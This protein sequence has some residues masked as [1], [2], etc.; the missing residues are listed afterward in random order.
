VEAAA[1]EDVSGV[2]GALLF[3][4]GELRF[5]NSQVW[6][7]FVELAGGK[8][9]PVVVM[10]TAARDPRASGQAV[11]DNLRKYGANAEVVLIA[12]KLRDIDFKAAVQDQA[13]VDKL[14][15]ARGIWFI[16][17]DQ[18][19]IT[20]ALLTEDGK[21]TPALEAI[22]EA[23]RNGAVIGGSSAG[24][25]VMSRWMFAN[26]P[27]SSLG[28]LLG[29]M[30]SGHGEAIDQGLGFIGD[31]W[32]V[33]QHFLTRGRF[34]RAL[35]AMHLLKL[36]YGIGV[37]EDTAVVF[38]AGKFEVVGYKGALVLD[39]GDAPVDKSLPAFNMKKA[40][41]SYLDAGDSL[42]IKTGHVTVSARKEAGCKI[43]PQ[44]K[45]FAPEDTGPAIYPDILG[46]WT[47]CEAM[48]Q[49]L[50]S[51]AGEVKGIAFALPD[52]DDKLGF[53][54]KIYRGPESVGW[55]TARGGN[56]AYTVL[57]VYVDITPVKLTGPSYEPLSSESPKPES[58][59][60]GSRP[61]ASEEGGSRWP[62]WI[63]IVA[64]VGGLLLGALSL[65][66]WRYRRTSRGT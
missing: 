52:R 53:E 55:Y 19:R 2:K 11:V 1:S 58:Q 18:Q 43:D 8:D 6:S 62:L 61:L 42:D 56:E 28:A 54:F 60:S 26:P 36:R 15:R 31:D 40:R 14:R 12:P 9:A 13:N 44:A 24:T 39:I 37:D 5:D 16:G 17:G 29:E 22:W 63:V 57:N 4:G 23:Y 32:F 50:D 65:G 10:P 45:D 20:Q 30:K 3:A 47:I 46:A 64:G 66:Y 34:A 41:L 59:E 21:M 25:A 48:Y 49:A 7:R 38:K 33:D 35:K 51:K 27:S